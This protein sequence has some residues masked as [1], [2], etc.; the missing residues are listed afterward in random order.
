ML[1]PGP[2]QCPLPLPFPA[3]SLPHARS[4]PHPAQWLPAGFSPATAIC[5]LPRPSS[6]LPPP[7]ARQFFVLA[8]RLEAISVGVSLF[9]SGTNGLLLIMLLVAALATPEVA[10]NVYAQYKYKVFSAREDSFASLTLGSQQTAQVDSDGSIS[11][12]A[13]RPAHHP[14]LARAPSPCPP[15]TPGPRTLALPTTH[16]WLAH[17]APRVALRRPGHPCN[18]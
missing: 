1:P 13:C 6:A 15:P 3:A 16:P 4:I 9:M 2:Q 14:P 10:F 7:R 11:G 12:Q 18:P 5:R 8:M 17:P